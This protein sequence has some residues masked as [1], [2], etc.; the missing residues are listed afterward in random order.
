MLVLGKMVHKYAG[1]MTNEKINGLLLPIIFAR[2]D[3]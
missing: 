1:V 2:Y 3:V